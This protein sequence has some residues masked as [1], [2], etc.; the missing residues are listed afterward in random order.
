VIDEDPRTDSERRWALR[1]RPLIVGEANPINGSAEYALWPDPPGCSGWRLCHV[2]M[3]ISRETY[4]ST[5][6]RANLFSVPP[7]RWRK[8]TAKEKAYELKSTLSQDRR[9][10]LLGK[11]VAEAFD[12]EA[13]LP[14]VQLDPRARHYVALPHPSGLSRT[15]NDPRA[16]DDCRESLD[17]YLGYPIVLFGSAQPLDRVIISFG[18]QELR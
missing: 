12:C 4:L 16:I 14:F 17:H 5:F 11:K 8:R 2:I 3:G 7:E 9:L 10:I 18:E 13:D 6:D 1:Q 15:W